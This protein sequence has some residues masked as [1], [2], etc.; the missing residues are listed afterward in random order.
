MTLQSVSAQPKYIK[1]KVIDKQAERHGSAMTAINSNCTIPPEEKPSHRAA[2]NASI[3]FDTL[4]DAETY[5]VNHIKEIFDA[6]FRDTKESCGISNQEMADLLYPA[7]PNGVI[8]SKILAHLGNEKHHVNLKIL[9]ALRF[10]FGISIDKILDEALAEERKNPHPP[11]D[12]Q[13]R[14]SGNT[15]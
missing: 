14:Q 3:K 2:R 4:D 6:A 9:A 15:R 10:A 5:V 13:K 8:V 11:K 1:R 12:C 7:I